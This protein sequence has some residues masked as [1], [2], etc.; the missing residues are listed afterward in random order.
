MQ[1]FKYC[2][3]LILSTNTKTNPIPLHLGIDNKLRVN[4]SSTFSPLEKQCHLYIL[5]DCPIRVGDWVY[6]E[7]SKEIYQFREISASYEKKIIATTDSLSKYN[8]PL[9]KPPQSL[10]QEYAISHNNRE[11][12]TEVL[13]QYTKEIAADGHTIIGH[14][15]V[16]NPDMTIN[17]KGLNRETYTREEVIK[18]MRDFALMQTESCN[19]VEYVKKNACLPVSVDKW[20]KLKFK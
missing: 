9:P 12:I 4:H 17:I 3:V 10:I 11:P 8:E 13:V 20:V 1:V 18:M 19:I 14:Q 2:P 15:L 5:S 7:I 16:V 6:N